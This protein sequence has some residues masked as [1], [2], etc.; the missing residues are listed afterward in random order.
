MTLGEEQEA[1][2]RDLC[3]LLQ[4]AF[5]MGY[6]VRIG[7][8]QRTIE[9]QK[10]YIKAGRSKTLNSRHLDKCAA[11]LHFT[12]NGQLCYP[13]ELGTYWE[14]LNTKNQWGGNWKSFKDEPHFERSK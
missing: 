13:K 3:K 10:L 14:S 12:K 4:A 2:S 1:F 9:Q 6:Q 11:D 7:E 5:D 8:V